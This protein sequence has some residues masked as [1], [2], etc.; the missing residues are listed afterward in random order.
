[1]PNHS[2]CPN[3]VVEPG[4]SS[5]NGGNI[6]KFSQIQYPFSLFKLHPHVGAEWGMVVRAAGYCKANVLVKVG[7]NFKKTRSVHIYSNHVG[8]RMDKTAANT[9]D[10]IGSQENITNTNDLEPIDPSVPLP[11]CRILPPVLQ[12]GPNQITKLKM[13]VGNANHY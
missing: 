5:Q 7:S 10:H 13:Q 12:C 2:N 8:G 3:V 1:M 4:C 6:N 11:G 9:L